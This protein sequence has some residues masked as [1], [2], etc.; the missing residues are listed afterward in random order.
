[1][2]QLIL[3]ENANLQGRHKHVYR[4]ESFLEDFND[5]TSSFVILEGQWDFF[6]D[7]NFDGETGGRTFGPGIY[8]WVGDLGV[9]N[10]AISSVRLV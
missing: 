1:M 10:N 6:I 9:A 4:S 5:L 2:P 3:F 7:A 8:A